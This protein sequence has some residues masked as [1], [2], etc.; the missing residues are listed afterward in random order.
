M[1]R[2]SPRPCGAETDDRCD[3]LLPRG[4]GLFERRHVPAH[5]ENDDPIGHLEDDV[6]V[7]RDDDHPEPLG[8]ATA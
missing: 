1:S 5:V 4:R 8:A 6:D 7:V 2:R 3:D